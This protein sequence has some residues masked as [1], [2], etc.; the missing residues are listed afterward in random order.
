[1]ICCGSGTLLLQL[2][3]P[4]M[5]EI[6]KMQSLTLVKFRVW[7]VYTLIPRYLFFPELYI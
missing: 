6:P 1:M 5:H 4:K 3:M 2:E 7:P